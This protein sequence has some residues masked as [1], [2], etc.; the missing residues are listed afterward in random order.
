M[1]MWEQLMFWWMLL[2]DAA[3]Q[4][5]LVG[6]TR[7]LLPTP[8][9]LVQAPLRCSCI[10]LFLLQASCTNFTPPRSKVKQSAEFRLKLIFCFQVQQTAL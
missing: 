3:Q 9:C 4:T 7:L 6:R 2:T 8:T 5:R 1:Q 10:V